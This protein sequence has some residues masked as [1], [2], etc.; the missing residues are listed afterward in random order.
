MATVESG[1]LELDADPSVSGLDAPIGTLARFSGSVFVKVGA[2]STAWVDPFAVYS[3]SRTYRMGSDPLVVVPADG[4]V[5]ID[6]IIWSGD[7]TAQLV[8]LALLVGIVGAGTATLRL[9]TGGTFGLPDG[10]EVLS[11]TV[12][13]PT[14]LS[15]NS[16]SDVPSAAVG[17]NLKATVELVG[18]TSAEVRAATARLAA[19]N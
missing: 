16:V 15:N 14:A 19:A 13:G 6:E 2:S 18:G 11:F 9:R 3:A 5:L 8:Q 7:F 10:T 12:I 4:E 17:V 1:I